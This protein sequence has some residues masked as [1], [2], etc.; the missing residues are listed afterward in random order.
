MAESIAASVRQ[1]AEAELAQKRRE[2]E[3]QQRRRRLIAVGALAA[4]AAVIAVQLRPDPGEPVGRV[5]ALNSE[6]KGRPSRR[7]VRSGHDTQPA[8]AAPRRR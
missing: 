7:P 4:A 8:G 2:R 1:R 6:I 5:V 3:Q